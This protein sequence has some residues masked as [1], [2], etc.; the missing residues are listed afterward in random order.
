[1][2][3][4]VKPEPAR[5]PAQRSGARPA[6]F[7]DLGVLGSVVVSILLVVGYFLVFLV[8]LTRKLDLADGT[9]QFLMIMFTT[10]QTMVVLV[11]AYWLGSSAS[12]ARKDQA[13]NNAA[14]IPPA[15]GEGR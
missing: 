15:A 12:S 10:L 2:A 3:N 13:L 7:Q 9:D 14:G 1:M 11:P 8:L 5:A 6:R 4:E